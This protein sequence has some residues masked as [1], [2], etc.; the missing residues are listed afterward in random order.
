MEE[1][2]LLKRYAYYYDIL[3]KL[4]E[5][6]LSKTPTIEELQ[7]SRGVVQAG[8]KE[9]K[10]IDFE[11]NLIDYLCYISTCYWVHLKI[12]LGMHHP[13]PKMDDCIYKNF[14]RLFVKNP[15]YYFNLVSPKE[16]PT[17]EDYYREVIGYTQFS[18]Y[19]YILFVAEDNK[20][21][22]EYLYNR[23]ND[24]FLKAFD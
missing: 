23:F 3:Q 18:A 16:K 19:W 8:Y 5:F 7:P 6:P 20:E 12:K 24:R 22:K 13:D 11:G 1:K 17:K 2:I 21:M 4:G 9:I 15:K 10:E 14:M